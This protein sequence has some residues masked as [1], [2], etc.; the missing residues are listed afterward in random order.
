MPGVVHTFHVE[1]SKGRAGWRPRKDS[2]IAGRPANQCTPHATANPAAHE[3]ARPASP[4]MARRCAPSLHGSAGGAVVVA[5]PPTLSSRTPQLAPCVL[6]SRRAGPFFGVLSMF[7]FLRKIRAA[8]A[9]KLRKAAWDAHQR[10]LKSGDTRRQHETRSALVAAT[11]AK[12]RLE[13][14]R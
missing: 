11:S 2:M 13:L 8:K 9:A 4:R 14:G 10:A 1:P 3:H 12:L 5:A 7:N 6:S